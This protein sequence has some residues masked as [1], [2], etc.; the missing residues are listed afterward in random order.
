VES[1]KAI[2]AS[3]AEQVKHR[4]RGLR[5]EQRDPV[6]A[7]MLLE[8]LASGESARKIMKEEGVDHH[9]LCGLRARHAEA[10][11]KRRE[12]LAQD[13][14]EMAEKVRVLQ[15]EK[16]DMLLEDPEALAKTNLRDL[17]MSYGIY[18]DKFHQSTE[19]NTV[20]IQHK[21]GAPSIE[22][23]MRA[24]MDAKEKLKNS[25]IEITVNEIKAGNQKG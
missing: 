9:V 17:A 6:R 13:A 21:G 18:A 16:M 20:T 7:T 3:V 19:G 11:G 2:A 22:D 12:V 4:G 8:R 24:I 14:M 5:L 23:A 10:L 1:R 15:H 25:S